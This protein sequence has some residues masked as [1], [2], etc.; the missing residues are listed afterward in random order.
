M[1]SQVRLT[2][3]IQNVFG[4]SK[5]MSTMVE[6]IPEDKLAGL[7]HAEVHYFNRSDCLTKIRVLIAADR[8]NSSYN[9]HGRVKP[10]P[11]GIGS[12]Y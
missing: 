2:V 3:C 1:R 4:A 6:P 7:D 5:P 9:H 11:G 10:L 8:V 12:M